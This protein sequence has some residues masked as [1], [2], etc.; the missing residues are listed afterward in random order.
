MKINLHLEV[1][2]IFQLDFGLDS[3]KQ[4][5]DTKALPAPAEDATLVEVHPDPAP[6]KKE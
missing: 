5:G 4:I 3:E 1:L 2:K 6:A